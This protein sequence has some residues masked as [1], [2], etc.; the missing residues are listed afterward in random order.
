MPSSARPRGYRLDGSVGSSARAGLLCLT[1]STGL[2]GQTPGPRFRI[3]PGD[4]VPVSFDE[5]LLTHVE[6]R[7]V[8]NPASPLHLLATSIVFREGRMTSDVLLSLDGGGSWRRFLF[9]SCAGDPWLSWGATERVYFSCLGAEDGPAPALVFHSVDGGRTW[10]APSPVPHDVPTAFDHVSTAVW[11]RQ[12]TNDVVYLAGLQGVRKED[13]PPLAATFVSVSQDGGLTFGMPHRFVWS[14]VMANA[15][16]PIVLDATTM[17]VAF[18]DYSVDGQSAIEHPR[19]WWVYSNDLG[20]SFS[21]NHY[22]TTL[23][24]IR[25]LPV[26]GGGWR[27]GGRGS[28]YLA[29][30]DF[31]GGEQGIFLVRS[32]DGGRSWGHPQPIATG[33]PVVW[34]AE[35]PVTAVDPAGRVGVAWYERPPGADSGCWR[36]RFTASHDDGET[37]SSPVTVSSELFC[38]K[39]GAVDG[40]TRWPA[41]GDYFGLVADGP[42]A[43]RALWADSRSGVW[44][45]RTTRIRLLEAP[46]P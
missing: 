16:N 38:A 9:P 34:R 18:V 7:V 2:G 45:L 10:S 42:G 25:T 3:Q 24:H 22:V 39:P 1:L 5:P 14:N 28:L 37:F 23:S 8:V 36:I 4:D 30:D 31:R 26:M 29:Y 46:D 43:F 15:I 17:G 41:G 33:D 27:H 11:S 35:N 44:Q 12:G 40:S 21:M 6:P 32:A 20:G 19:I 13:G